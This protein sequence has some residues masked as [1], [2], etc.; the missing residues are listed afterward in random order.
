MI[1]VGA[2]ETTARAGQVVSEVLDSTRLSF[3]HFLQR[4]ERAPV[5]VDPVHAELDLDEVEA[6]A[7]ELRVGRRW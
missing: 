1:G 2:L 5:D 6:A 7:R 3:G 4:L